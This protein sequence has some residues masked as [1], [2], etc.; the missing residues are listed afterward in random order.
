MTPTSRPVPSGASL[1][2]ALAPHWL[3][4]APRC[5]VAVLEALQQHVPRMPSALG[6]AAPGT[7]SAASSAAMGLRAVS[8]GGYAASTPIW[9]LAVGRGHHCT[10]GRCSGPAGRARAGTACMAIREGGRTFFLHIGCLTIECTGAR[11]WPAPA[12]LPVA[13]LTG[14]APSPGASGP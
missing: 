9:L 3:V 5:R 12:V 8:D 13:A 10:V 11:W 6:P 4:A 7:Q 14:C 2:P 1:H